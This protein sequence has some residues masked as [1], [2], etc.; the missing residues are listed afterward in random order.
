MIKIKLLGVLFSI[1]NLGTY[2]YFYKKRKND[3]LL[4]D[5]H[6][7]DDKLYTGNTAA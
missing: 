5:I 2:L 7:K 4:D 6:N 3:P 1:I